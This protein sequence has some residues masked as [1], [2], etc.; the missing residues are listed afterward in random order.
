MNYQVILVDDHH[1]VRQGLR[2]LIDTVK[3][4]N[5]VADFPTGKLLLD[6]LEENEQPDIILLDLVMPEMNGI[7]IT[8]ILKKNIQT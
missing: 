2:F 4:F 7:E 6:Y 3:D 1:I 5:I 8:G